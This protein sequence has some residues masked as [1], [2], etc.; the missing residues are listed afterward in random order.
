MSASMPARERAFALVLELRRTPATRVAVDCIAHRQLLVG[1]SLAG[2]S[3]VATT[4]MPSPASS[5][6]DGPV[7]AERQPARRAP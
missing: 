6:A 5:G 2:P 4:Q 3:R 7:A 1:A